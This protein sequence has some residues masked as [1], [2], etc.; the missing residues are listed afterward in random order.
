[1]HKPDSAAWLLLAITLAEKA[2]EGASL[3]GIIAA[4]DYTN[5]AIMTY[6]EFTEGLALLEKSGLAEQRG[7]I[8]QTTPFF[9]HWHAREVSSTDPAKRLSVYH[10]LQLIRDYLQGRIADLANDAV[11]PVNFPPEVFQQAVNDYLGK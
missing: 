4:A 11:H 1:M 6:A 5:H 10:E 7:H 2:E 8:I 3:R 9:R